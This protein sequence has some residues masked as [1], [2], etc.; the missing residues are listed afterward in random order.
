MKLSNPLNKYD[1]FWGDF[2]TSQFS[3][4]SVLQYDC[5]GIRLKDL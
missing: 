3:L 4:E 1:K 5:S 2:K